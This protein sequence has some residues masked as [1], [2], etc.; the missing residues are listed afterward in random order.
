MAPRSLAQF[1]Q[2]RL[3]QTE[4][5]RC[6]RFATLQRQHDKVDGISSMQP[7][8]LDFIGVS[9]DHIQDIKSKRQSPAP[10]FQGDERL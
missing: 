3:G 6:F 7:L 9:S 10:I 8:D 2:E 5:Q 4:M 1:W